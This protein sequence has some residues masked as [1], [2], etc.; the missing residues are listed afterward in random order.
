M[1]IVHAKLQLQWDAISKKNYLMQA[2]SKLTSVIDHRVEGSII[3]PGIAQ[4]LKIQRQT[5]K[6]LHLDVGWKFQ[7]Y[8]DG[9][10]SYK[11][12]YI[13]CQVIQAEVLRYWS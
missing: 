13:C 3:Y 9:W 8:H 6:L 11:Y 5:H 10:I 2:Y 12:I 4:Q 1:P 7:N